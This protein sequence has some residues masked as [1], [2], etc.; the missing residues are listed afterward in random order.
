MVVVDR[1]EGRLIKKSDL[2]MEEE[3]GWGGLVELFGTYC[4]IHF[5]KCTIEDM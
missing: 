1:A 2:S 5:C 3:G 4:A